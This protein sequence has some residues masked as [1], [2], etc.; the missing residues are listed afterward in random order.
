MVGSWALWP[1]CLNHTWLPLEVSISDEML[2]DIVENYKK[3]GS[4]RQLAKYYEQCITAAGFSPMFF[5]LF[6]IV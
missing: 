3:G 5:L 1:G 4:V 2:A 6:Q